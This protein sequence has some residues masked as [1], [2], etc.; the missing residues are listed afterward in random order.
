MISFSEH[1][2]LGDFSRHDSIH[3]QFFFLVGSLAQVFCESLFYTQ[4]F[5]TQANTCHGTH[6][7]PGHPG[8]TRYKEQIENCFSHFQLPNHEKQSNASA[9]VK[10][11]RELHR[12]GEAY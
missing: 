9:A 1:I 8:N 10:W 6:D 5:S 12:L 11:G 3:F 4:A 7:N 2:P